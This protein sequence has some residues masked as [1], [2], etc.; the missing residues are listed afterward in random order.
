[1]GFSYFVTQRSLDRPLASLRLAWGS[2]GMML[3]GIV[4]AG[5]AMPMGTVGCVPDE[6]L[7]HSCVSC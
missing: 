5:F 1:M 3:V 2:F 7:A 6:I 4:L